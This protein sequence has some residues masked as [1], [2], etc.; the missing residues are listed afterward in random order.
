M[1]NAETAAVVKMIEPASDIKFDCSSQSFMKTPGVIVSLVRTSKS[2]VH[3]ISYNQAEN[4][5][6]T[7]N[8]YGS[9][10]PE[11]DPIDDPVEDSEDEK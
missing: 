5:I 6:K 1:L 11:D 9:K 2:E 10:Y 7:I 8:N 4:T 3:L